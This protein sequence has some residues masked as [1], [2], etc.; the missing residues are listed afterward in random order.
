[1]DVSDITQY[2]ASSGGTITDDGGASEAQRGAVWGA[3]SQPTLENKTGVTNDGTGTGSFT[4]RLGNLEPNTIYYVRAYAKNS[5]GVAYRNENSFTTSE[6]SGP[7]YGQLID[8]R[9]G[10]TKTYKTVMIGSQ[11]WM[12]E[13]LAYLPSVSPSSEG[14]VTT[15]F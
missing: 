12:A 5:A 11:E 8:N 9:G 14:S 4:S 13:N 7:V 10:E 6:S 2:S 15:P 3:S 1:M